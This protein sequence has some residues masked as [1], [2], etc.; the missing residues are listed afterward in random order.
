MAQAAEP[1]A[2]ADLAGHGS[3][4]AA[5]NGEDADLLDLALV[6]EMILLV[7]KI[8]GAAARA[9]RHADLALLVE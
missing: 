7:G 9:Q 5:G 1:E 4:G 6:V 2:H 8:V 3:H